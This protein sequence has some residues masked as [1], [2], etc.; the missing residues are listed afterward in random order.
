MEVI[1]NPGCPTSALC[2]KK[3]WIIKTTFPIILIAMLAK[4]VTEDAV[5]VLKVMFGSAWK[6]WRKWQAQRN[7]M[8]PYFLSNMY[9]RFKVGF[10][11]KSE[12]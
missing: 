3:T 2:D 9:G 5:G 4:P 6:S 10:H 11:C 7:W 12:L 1:K 8:W